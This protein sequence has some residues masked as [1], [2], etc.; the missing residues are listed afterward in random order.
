MNDYELINTWIA[1]LLVAIIGGT[2]AGII[3]FFITS[4]NQSKEKKQYLLNLYNSIDNDFQKCIDIYI[5]NTK[6]IDEN[7]DTLK[8]I[9]T[10]IYTLSTESPPLV[11]IDDDKYAINE[12]IESARTLNSKLSEVENSFFQSAK[13][14]SKIELLNK[15]RNSVLMFCYN[16]KIVIYNLLNDIQD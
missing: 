4:S 2:I 9:I 10:K 8:E 14:R 6:Q 12:I 3:I 13:N 1:P 7:L 15:L 11:N 16:N 5:Y